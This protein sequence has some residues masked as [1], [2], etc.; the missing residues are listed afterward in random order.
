[1]VEAVLQIPQLSHPGDDFEGPDSGGICQAVDVGANP[2]EG[3]L[4]V[5]GLV[6]QSVTWR[7]K[8]KG[9]WPRLL[10]CLEECRTC[11]PCPAFPLKAG[12]DVLPVTAR[13]EDHEQG[14]L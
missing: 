4:P 13:H 3:G 6:D 11:I 7:S 9:K 5:L 12:G 14:M 1:M 10:F 2:V 8:E